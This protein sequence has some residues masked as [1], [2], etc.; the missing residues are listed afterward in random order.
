[1]KN[2]SNN[3]FTE[4]N[5]NPVIEINHRGEIEYINL[6]AR[7]L[8]PT[9]KLQGFN[10]PLFS[11]LMDNISFFK[12]SESQVIIFAK[13]VVY[14]NTIYEQQ[15][16]SVP[17]TNSL[18]IYLFDITHRKN[19]EEELKIINKEL[20]K[21]VVERT[22]ELE[23]AKVKAEGLA[24][25]AEEASRA[26]AAFLAVMSHEM[27]TPLNGVL[28]MTGL[29]LD[30]NLTEEQREFADV[31]RVSGEILLSVIGDILDFSK[32]ESGRMEIEHVEFSL[33]ILIDEIIDLMSAQIG[34]K[35]I[36]IGAFIESDVP[37]HLIGDVSHIRQILNNF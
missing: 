36:E 5:P 26:K 8:F 16:F 21:R 25:R 22:K 2:I 29:L 15:I 18:Y 13:E 24:E 28:G 35:K 7:A 9:L 32:I 27:R 11:G 19:L 3:F 17:E 33:Q 34:R 30:T 10:H 31:V 1:M 12:S 14:F 23:S 4:W 37:D 6:T 20:E